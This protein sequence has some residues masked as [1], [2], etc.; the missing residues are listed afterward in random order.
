LGSFQALPNWKALDSFREPR[1][2]LDK[3]RY[4]PGKPNYEIKQ[5]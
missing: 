4:T 3:Q 2:N 5:I 1:H